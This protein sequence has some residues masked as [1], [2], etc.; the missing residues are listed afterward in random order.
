MRSVWK[1]ARNN[2]NSS[3]IDMKTK[4]C[5]Y[6]KRLNTKSSYCVLSFRDLIILVFA[7][8]RDNNLVQTFIIRNY[9]FGREGRRNVNHDEKSRMKNSSSRRSPEVADYHGWSSSTSLK[10]ESS[11]FQ[12]WPHRF[13]RFPTSARPWIVLFPVS[14][15]CKM[16]KSGAFSLFFPRESLAIIVE[17]ARPP[18]SSK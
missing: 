1:P 6:R 12:S 10:H 15:Y 11:R 14:S 8:H 2:L 9:V 7:I 16:E 3:I 5:A 17:I 18:N 13:F 4:F